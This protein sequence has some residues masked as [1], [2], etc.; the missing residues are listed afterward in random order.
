MRYFVAVSVVAVVTLLRQPFS[1]LLGNSAPFTFY[2]P[3]VVVAGWFGGFGPGMVAT[4]LSG[5]CART[6][7]FPPYGAFALDN[8][9]AVFR[10]GVFVFGCSLASFLC[11]LLHRRTDELAR[12][13]RLLEEKVKDRTKHLERSLQDMEVFA[14]SASHDLRAPLRWMRGF[15]AILLE[16]YGPVLDEKGRGHLHRIEEGA[17]RLGQLI[18]DLLKFAKVSGST[19]EL[20][21]TTLKD[22]VARLVAGLPQFEPAHIDLNYEGCTHTV[23]ANR[24]LLQQMIQN[25]VDN[26][27]KFVPAGVRPQI[28]LRSELRGEYVRLWVEDNGIG[29]SPENQKKLFQLFSRAAPGYAGTGIG[30]AIVDR[31]AAKMNGRVG[32][33]SEVG[34]GSRFWIELPPA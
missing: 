9:P 26:G 29:I 5:Y 28:R 3:A 18:D 30:L 11:G 25:L 14:Y 23:L 34:K 22:A 13:K 17:T 7:F 1:S 21:P 4:L 24:T 12:E 10:L 19:V 27:V 8:W 6:W 33:E 15:S 2:F 31:A 20:Q 32:V 16:D